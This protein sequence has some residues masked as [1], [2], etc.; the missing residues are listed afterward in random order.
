L[1]ERFLKQ[2]LRAR[3]P[4]TFFRSLGA[5]LGYRPHCGSLKSK[6]NKHNYRF[7]IE[8]QKKINKWKNENLIVNWIELNGNLE[9]F[10]NELINKYGPLFN[11]DK[12]SLALEELKNLRKECV[13]IANR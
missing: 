3:G 13:E 10:E 9:E 12:N 8:D 2:E 6:S 1:N 4:G 5:V 11:I 7:S